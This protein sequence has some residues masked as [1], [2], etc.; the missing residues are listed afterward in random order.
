MKQGVSYEVKRCS[1]FVNYSLAAKEVYL[2]GWTVVYTAVQT[3][4]LSRHSNLSSNVVLWLY[5]LHM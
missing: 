3:T 2:V 5:G 4:V 1:E